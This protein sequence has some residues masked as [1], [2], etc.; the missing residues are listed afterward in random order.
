[1][2]DD[3]SGNK[4]HVLPS[5]MDGRGGRLALIYSIRNRALA[6]AFVSCASVMPA[7]AGMTLTSTDIEEGKPIPQAQMYPRCGGENVSPALA[8]GGIPHRAKSIALTMI[9]IDVKPAHWS[10]WVIVGLPPSSGFI[11]RGAKVLPEGAHAL[12]SNFG[13]TSYN[14]PCPPLGTHRYRFTIWALRVAEPG[15]SGDEK[16]TD[17]EAT[18]EKSALDRACITAFAR[19]GKATERRK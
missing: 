8:W 11:P 6:G 13:G 19:S 15:L 10:H 5:M 16:A 18:L 12:A 7:I 3:T 14:G 1:M 17:V 9:D 4:C 2:P